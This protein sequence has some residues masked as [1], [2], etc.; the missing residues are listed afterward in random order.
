MSKMINLVAAA[1]RRNKFERTGRLSILDPTNLTEE[2]LGEAKAAIEA[3][4]VPTEAMLSCDM[5]LG[6]YGY[7]DDVYQADPREIWE[8]MIDEALK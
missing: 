2:E 8:T 4:R 1:I 3:M 5:P 6:G 7:G